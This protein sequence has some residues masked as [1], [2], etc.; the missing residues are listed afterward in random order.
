MRLLPGNQTIALVLLHAIFAF[1]LQ[2]TDQQ[3]L[4]LVGGT[5]I[6]ASDKPPIF[7]AVILLKNGRIQAIGPRNSIVIPPSV[8]VLELRGKFV[9]PGLIDTNVH[10]VLMTIPEFFIKYEGRFEDIALESAQLGLKYGFTTLMDTWGPLEPLLKARDRL[11]RGEVLGSRVLIGGNIVGMGGPFTTSMLGSAP[12]SSSGLRYSGWV[13][14][15]I[16]KRIDDLWEANMGPRLLALTPGEI[17]QATRDY[18]ARGVDF[19]KVA[20]SD[21]GLQP[22][23]PLMFSPEQLRA[24]REEVRKAGRPF[25]THTFTLASLDI[26]INSG[27]DLLQHPNVMMPFPST[28][29]QIATRDELIAR[30]K[31]EHIYCSLMMVPSKEQLRI[32]REWNPNDHPHDAALNRIMMSRKQGAESQYKQQLAALR[33]WLEAKLP[34]TLAT[35]AGLEL[36]DLGPVVWGRLGRAEFE[37]M[38]ALQDAGA[39]PNEILMAATRRGAEAYGLGKELGTLE[40]GK[41]ADVLVLDGDPLQDVHNFRKINLVIKGGRVVDRKALPTVHVAPYFEP[42]MPWPF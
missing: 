38:E 9:T 27:P 41:I 36:S 37:R 10:L 26:A 13:D 34:F 35:D 5:A 18:L 29:A 17:A 21:H 22:V 14:P 31:R 40:V 16:Q 25:V 33:P 19:V 6:T 7:D 2:Q 11:D 3:P 30:I 28:P 12:I 24:I 32:L 8:K 20:V 4:A 1:G 39:L 42:E 23:E 15:E